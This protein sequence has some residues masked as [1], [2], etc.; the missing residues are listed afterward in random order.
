[1]QCKAAVN[2]GYAQFGKV[3]LRFLLQSIDCPSLETGS[4]GILDSLTQYL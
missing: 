1:M 3:Y 2:V 4:V